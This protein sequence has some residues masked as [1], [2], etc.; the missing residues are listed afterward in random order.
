MLAALVVAEVSKNLH[1]LIRESVIQC[2]LLGCVASL[3]ETSRGA[4]VSTVFYTQYRILY[5]CT[6]QTGYEKFWGLR[7]HQKTKML[8]EDDIFCGR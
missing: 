2:C 6:S 1:V 8:V 3:Q 4:V 5:V 7:P